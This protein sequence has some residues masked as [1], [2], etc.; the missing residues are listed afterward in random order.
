[1]GG[2]FKLREGTRIQVVGVVQ[3]GKYKSFT[4]TSQPAMFFPL[5]QSPSSESWMVVR[6]GRDP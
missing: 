5:L 1:M 3:D 4:E 6:S 2:Y